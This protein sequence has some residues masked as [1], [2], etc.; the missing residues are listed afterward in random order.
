MLLYKIKVL[1]L[2][3]IHHLFPIISIKKA[4]MNLLKIIKRNSINNRFIKIVAINNLLTKMSSQNLTFI[5]KFINNFITL[6]LY[7]VNE[8]EDVVIFCNKDTII[9]DFK[10]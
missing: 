2:Q 9:E 1:A 5:C 6:K 4:F 10:D 3:V 7:R 8:L